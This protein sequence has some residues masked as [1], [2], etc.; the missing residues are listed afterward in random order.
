MESKERPIVLNS[1]RF[2]DKKGKFILREGYD[3]VFNNHETVE[4][5]IQ[6]RYE[7]W[8]EKLKKELV[9]APSANETLEEIEIQKVAKLAAKYMNISYKLVKTSRKRKHTTVKQYIIHI[10]R[11]RKATLESIG[12]VLGCG[13][14]NVIYH[15]NQAKG[16]IE[17]DKIYREKYEEVED[18]V[19]SQLRGKFKEDG[20]GTKAENNVG[21]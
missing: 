8:T 20:S 11:G 15:L 13:H 3:I 9:I 16:F 7:Y 6:E 10:C 1:L 17:T 4:I 14:S 18:F 5:F 21:R 2:S 19:L 12:E